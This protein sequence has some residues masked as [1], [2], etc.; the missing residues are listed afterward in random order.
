MRTVKQQLKQDLKVP[1]I[2]LD[3]HYSESLISAL[4]VEFHAQL[5]PELH[6]LDYKK[7]QHHTLWCEIILLFLMALGLTI[8]EN[9]CGIVIKDLI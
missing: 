5:Y 9:K 3:V 6:L 1:W 7:K 8:I 2:G 4:S